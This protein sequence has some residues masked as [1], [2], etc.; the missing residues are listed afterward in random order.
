MLLSVD[1]EIYW[2]SWDYLPPRFEW[3]SRTENRR[4]PY[5]L[6]I[7]FLAKD[8][9]ANGRGWRFTYWYFAIPLTLLSACLLLWKPR[10]QKPSPT[11]QPPTT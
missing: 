10:N 4:S 7:L 1:G 2:Y 9:V 5:M 11:S 8:N 3:T 6:D